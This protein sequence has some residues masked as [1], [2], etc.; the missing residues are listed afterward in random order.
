MTYNDDA[1]SA[2]KLLPFAVIG[3]REKISVGGHQL[4]VRQFPWGL[5]EG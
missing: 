5:V 2:Q 3:S 4:R 1:T